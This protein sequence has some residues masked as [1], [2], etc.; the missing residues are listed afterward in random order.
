MI[1]CHEFT[2]LNQPP[3]AN[4]TLTIA[5]VECQKTYS[6][7]IRSEMSLNKS[8]S[9]KR[10][11]PEPSGP[12]KPRDQQARPAPPT[13][14]PDHRATTPA[15]SSG[16]S[17][18]SADINAS[19]RAAI[20]PAKPSSSLH[21][22]DGGRQQ[23]CAEQPARTGTAPQAHINPSVF[24]FE[25]G[26]LAR[27]SEETRESE[28]R[29]KPCTY[30]SSTTTVVRHHHFSTMEQRAFARK[31]T[32][33]DFMCP[34]CQKLE[35][36][37]QSCNTTRRVILSDSTLY[38]IWNEQSLPKKTQHIEIECIVGAR[39][40]DLTR[41]LV[42]N[43]LKYSNRLEIIVIAG[44][45][46]VGKNDDVNS[47][48]EEFREL[49][50]LVKDHSLKHKHDPPSYTSIST[51]IL[52]PKYCSFNV[53]ANDPELAEWVPKPGFQDRYQAIKE[54]NLAVKALN[55]EEQVSWLNLHMQGVKIL[56]SGPQHKYDTRPR[57]KAIWREREVFRKLHFTMENKLKIIVYMQNTF[58]MN[59]KRATNTTNTNT[60]KTVVHT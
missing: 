52:P 11:H 29:D 48:V 39:V 54:I 8:K 33:G 40:R 51:L 13:T 2:V 17:W 44:I 57:A 7:I 58:K 25:S 28:Y 16:V 23:D 31:W 15:S 59:A 49:K 41:A 10:P 43:V 4:I 34:V 56:K 3:L 14:E 6:V 20:R 36:T 32:K 26:D 50:E 27:L 37:I 42:K 19:F 18:Y 38:G 46:N 22:H 30:C 53:P 47:I 9:V 1:I 21:A 55:E 45:N 5:I 35:P 24:Q 12:V 60:G